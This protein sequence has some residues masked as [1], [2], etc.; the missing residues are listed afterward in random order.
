LVLVEA[1]AMATQRALLGVPVPTRLRVWN[2]NG[3]DPREETERRIAAILLHYNIDPQELEDW[4]FVDCGRDT[5]ICIAERR[6]NDVI[7]TPD[8]EALT[9]EIIRL[10]VDVFTLD[11]FVKT[12]C[13]PENDNGMIDQV[14]RRYADR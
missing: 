2:W 4:L 1:V 9:A 14:A 5:P 11:P 10:K 7:F 3:E 6:R 12:H 8:A 13:L